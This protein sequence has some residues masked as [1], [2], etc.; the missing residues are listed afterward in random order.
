MYK[1]QEYVFCYVF[2]FCKKHIILDACMFELFQKFKLR[3]K[4]Y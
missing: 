2:F 1:L 4:I 3:N